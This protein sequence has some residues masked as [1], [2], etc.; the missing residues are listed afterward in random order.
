MIRAV[1]CGNKCLHTDI[2]GSAIH[3]GAFMAR[4]ITFTKKDFEYFKTVA[5]AGTVNEDEC[6]LGGIVE[7]AV[8]CDLYIETGTDD[9]S[10]DGF[11]YKNGFVIQASVYLLDGDEERM[12]M[13][14]MG[15]PVSCESVFYAGV[16]DTYEETYSGR[17]E[18]RQRGRIQFA[19]TDNDNVC[20]L[21]VWGWLCRYVPL[22]HRLKSN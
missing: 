6:C 4:R 12:E 18:K 15:H 10:A 1:N 5:E 11:R 21:C 8:S 17:A 19:E 7:N 9:T 16:C 22:T 20:P 2:N 3:E 13:K 14:L